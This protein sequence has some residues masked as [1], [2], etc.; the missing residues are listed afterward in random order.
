MPG[1]PPPTMP[2]PTA[3][4]GGGSATISCSTSPRPSGCLLELGE[5]LRHLP[6]R[7]DRL[8]S[9]QEDEIVDVAAEASALLQRRRE[10]RQIGR[11]LQDAGGEQAHRLDVAGLDEVAAIV[12]VPEV[13]LGAGEAARRQ[14]LVDLDQHPRPATADGLH[15]AVEHGLLVAFDVDL[16]EADIAFVRA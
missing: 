2:A 9:R 13:G 4:T 3:S 10:V 6:Q 15:R 7:L 11:V 16:D 14:A 1:R 5:T 8:I 12:E